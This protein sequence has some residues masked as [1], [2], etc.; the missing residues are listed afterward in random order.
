[1]IVVHR[2]IPLAMKSHTDDMFPP[3]AL[4]QPPYLETWASVPERSTVGLVF[5]IGG[6]KPIIIRASLARSIDIAMDAYKSGLSDDFELGSWKWH[7][8]RLGRVL[9]DMRT[10]FTKDNEFRREVWRQADN[11]G[12]LADAAIKI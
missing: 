7:S 4:W 10:A 11:L 6:P 9:A 8:K 3:V 5:G 12:W 2:S 1:M